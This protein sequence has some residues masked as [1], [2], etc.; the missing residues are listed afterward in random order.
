[1]DLDLALD[2]H[3][4]YSDTYLRATVGEHHDLVVSVGALSPGLHYIGV[5][6]LKGSRESVR[7]CENQETHKHEDNIRYDMAV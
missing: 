2:P 5:V 4:T 1:M 7:V 6:D 3:S